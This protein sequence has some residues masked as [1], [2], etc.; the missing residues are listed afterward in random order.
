MKLVRAVTLGIDL[1]SFIIMDSRVFLAPRGNCG[2]W[3]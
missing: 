3:P 2:E 1:T